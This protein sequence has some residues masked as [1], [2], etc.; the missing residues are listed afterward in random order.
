M[1]KDERRGTPRLALAKGLDTSGQ[2]A[3]AAQ[4]NHAHTQQFVAHLQAGCPQRGL[5]IGHHRRHRRVGA[6][7]GGIGKVQRAGAQQALGRALNMQGQRDQPQ[8]HQ[9]QHQQPVKGP[10]CPQAPEGFAVG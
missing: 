6:G 9:Q 10:Q 4:V 2:G 5:L 7:P 8:R 1:A 3:L